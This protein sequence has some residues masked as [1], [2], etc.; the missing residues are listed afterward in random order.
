MCGTV[1]VLRF[2]QSAARFVTV[3]RITINNAG[4]SGLS[5]G[6]PG[7]PP[8][9]T[10]SAEYLVGYQVAADPLGRAVALAARQQ[11]VSVLFAAS[12]ATPEAPEALESARKVYI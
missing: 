5:P 2:S 11:R 10:S 4:A 7:E 6:L 12:Y 1:A 8:G 9:P 3:Q